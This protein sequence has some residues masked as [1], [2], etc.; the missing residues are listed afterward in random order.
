M[1]LAGAIWCFAT[2]FEISAL[3]TQTVIFWVKFEYL[4]VVNIAPLWLLF[5]LGFTGQ[6]RWLPRRYLALFWII[7]ALILAFVFT[8]ESHNLMWRSVH[9][10]TVN[11]TPYIVYDYGPMFWV[12]AI[13]S[14]IIL[15]AGALVIISTLARYPR[16]YRRQTVYI[17]AGIIIPWIGSLGYVLGLTPSID[18]TPLAITISGIIFTWSILRYGFLDLI[19]VARDILIES[20]QDG[21]LVLDAQNRV[22]DINPTARRMLG[23]TESRPAISQNIAAIFKLWAGLENF[24]WDIN[25]TSTE[26]YPLNNP[27]SCFVLSLSSLYDL[28]KRLAGKLVILRDVSEMK[29]VEKAEREQ[30]T[31]A[32]TLQDAIAVLNSTL[33][34]DEVLD[35]ILAYIER[36]VPHDAA[37]IALLDDQG[38]VHIKRARGYS[39][40]QLE[41]YIL[42]FKVPYDR[43]P[44]WRKMVEERKPQVVPDTL[45][46]P[47]WIRYPEVEWIHSYAGAPIIFKDK[48][49][50]LLNLESSTT[51][52]FT[53]AH[54]ERLQTFAD[55]A[56][57]AIEKAQL[58]AEANSRAEVMSTINRIG[59]AITS[60]LDLEL[61]LKTLHMQLQQTIAMDVFYIA[62]YDNITKTIT[63]PLWFEGNQYI[64]IP[65]HDTNTPSLT[66][67]IIK[68]GK[69]LAFV[70]TLAPEFLPPAPILRSGG[71][72]S[73]AYVAAPLLLSEKVL[74]VISMQRYQPDAFTSDQ[75][76]LLEILASQASITIENTR[77][78]SQ[79][80]QMA[81]T[82]SVT[83]LFNRR[84]FIQ[85][86]TQE[87]ER[88]LRYHKKLT[89]MMMDIDHF[90]RVNDT[91]GHAVGD[92]VL[93]A[94]GQL[95]QESL[96]TNDVIG[97][98]GGD[99]FAVILPETDLIEARV[100]A[101]RLRVLIEEKENLCSQGTV[102]VTA[103]FGL[104]IFA[105]TLQ[106]LESLLAC[107]D[108][109]LYAAKQGGRN[110]VSVYQQPNTQ[111]QEASTTE[112]S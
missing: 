47:N 58:Y 103:S 112:P 97:R 107:T 8:N 49:I 100:V 101:E 26:I 41:D 6:D 110:R 10:D 66:G 22:V 19:P 106:N 46:G 63:F 45:N 52:F 33:D 104:A 77:L 86:A 83:D 18:L 28:R 7:P 62:L 27:E 15:F 98:Y 39:Q 78:F 56:A 2:A 84:Q 102:R 91:Y 81:T 50:G 25:T 70:D 85:L 14:Y 80:E 92:Q 75:I 51:G 13:Y 11:A 38:M 74:G 105:D 73:R 48:V 57:V 1:N 96:R 95:C 53:Q 111:T 4:G 43:F 30:R 71:Q 32:E 31:M 76:R 24:R 16:L 54:A 55:Q 36:V 90:K 79:M 87:V 68:N 65:P 99:E 64:Q 29:L 82:D 20:M 59:L 17:L 3:D 109:A 108:Q 44:N 88:T 40:R 72:P 94:V 42:K 61:V 34:Y 37:T 69:T 5:S 21:V 35:L 9:I 93:Y 67:Y 23:T 12:I 89:A 60:G